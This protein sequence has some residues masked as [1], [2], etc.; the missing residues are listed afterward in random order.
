MMQGI[1]DERS[2]PQWPRSSAQ[3]SQPSSG[4]LAQKEL[5]GTD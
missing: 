4:D 1:R 3:L 5:T 2:P